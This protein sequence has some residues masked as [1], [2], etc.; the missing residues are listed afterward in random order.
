MIRKKNTTNL[1]GRELI[2]P[3]KVFKEVS[4]ALK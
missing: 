1:V 3:D 2:I 4:N